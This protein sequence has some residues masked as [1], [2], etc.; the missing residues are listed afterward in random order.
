MAKAATAGAGLA[1]QMERMAL[2]DVT[3]KAAAAPVP[4]G[5]AGK[6]KTIEQQFVKLSQGESTGDP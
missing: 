1:T 5:A 4:S 2:G 3:K 6:G